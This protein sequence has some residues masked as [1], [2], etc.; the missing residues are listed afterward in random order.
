MFGAFNDPFNSS[1]P[2]TSYRP[3]SSRRTMTPGRPHS[4]SRA[5]VEYYG[6]RPTT[7]HLL[8]YG[9][10]KDLARSI[11]LYNNKV[12]ILERNYSIRLKSINSDLAIAR[13]NERRLHEIKRLRKLEKKRIKAATKIQNWWRLIKKHH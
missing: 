12:L 1:S 8:D 13:K 6:H 10:Q 4:F 11:N 7:S 2:T 9:R 3:G 5:S